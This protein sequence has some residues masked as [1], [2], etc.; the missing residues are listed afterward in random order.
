M[1]SEILEFLNNN[2]DKNWNE[3][4]TDIPLKIPCKENIVIEKFL[5]INHIKYKYHNAYMQNKIYPELKTSTGEIFLPNKFYFKNSE[6]FY[7]HLLHEVIH[8]IGWDKQILYEY[9]LEEVIAEIGS[10]LLA[11]ILN[12]N[13]NRLTCYKY[14]HI[15]IDRYIDDYPVGY[16][17]A[18][19]LCYNEAIKRI[20]FLRI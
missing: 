5:K 9:D 11:K 14:I 7:Y 15:W 12:L 1:I 19:K 4:Y 17:N 16:D 6:D 2:K 8:K 20:D 3:A 10:L 18:L 13:I